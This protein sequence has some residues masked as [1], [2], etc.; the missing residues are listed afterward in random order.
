MSTFN[1]TAYNIMTWVC[2]GWL[3]E[4]QFQY[5][6]QLFEAWIWLVCMLACVTS[7]LSRATLI[8]HFM[9]YFNK[10]QMNFK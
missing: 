6:V 1:N 3:H 4:V 8:G 9:V 7:Q 10:L 2:A 5:F